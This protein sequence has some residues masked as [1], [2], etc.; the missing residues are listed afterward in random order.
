LEF[1]RLPATHHME[2]S[3]NSRFFYEFLHLSTMMMVMLMVLCDVMAM[4]MM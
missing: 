1:Q 2:L 3:Q 4:A